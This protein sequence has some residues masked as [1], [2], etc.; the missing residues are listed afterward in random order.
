MITL[1][2]DWQNVKFK[3]FE[4]DRYYYIDVGKETHGR[5]SFRLWV[6]SRLVEKDAIGS[7]GVKFPA[8]AFINKTEKG[9]LVL[10]PSDSLI[11]YNILVECGFRGSSSFQ[12]IEPKDAE[13]FKYSVYRSELGSLGVSD[14]ALVVAKGPI[15]VKWHRSGRT[16][17]EPKQGVTVIYPNGKEESLE[18]VDEEQ[19]TELKKELE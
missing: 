12:I 13:I 2:V 14:G 10:K 7:E 16:Y 9:T 6:S 8:K 5:P 15:K 18:F 17:G 11:T 19:L 1:L 3:E 4:G